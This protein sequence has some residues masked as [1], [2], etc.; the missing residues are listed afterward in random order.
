MPHMD[1]IETMER[2][3]SDPDIDMSHIPVIAL[4]ANAISGAKEMYLEKGFSDYLSKPING[5][6]LSEMLQKWLPKEKINLEQDVSE[7]EKT[8]PA[9]AAEYSPKE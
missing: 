5:W 8:P 7:S 2:L 4:T 9:H 1:G 6:E 3:L